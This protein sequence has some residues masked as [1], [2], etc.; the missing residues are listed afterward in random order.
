M[1]FIEYSALFQEIVNGDLIY[2]QHYFATPFINGLLHVFTRSTLPRSQY[3]ILWDL[4]RKAL[5]FQRGTNDFGGALSL[6]PWLK[7]V[8]PNYSGYK[9]LR[10]GNQS[11]LDFFTVSY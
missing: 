6:T 8:M 1:D 3:S 9:N 4:A 5:L 11:L 2:L 10:K 7:D